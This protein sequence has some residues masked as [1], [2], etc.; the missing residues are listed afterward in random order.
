MLEEELH[1]ESK[2]PT[3]QKVLSKNK[4]KPSPVTSCKCFSQGMG[5]KNVYSKMYTKELPTLSCGKGF[6]REPRKSL[7]VG[8]EKSRC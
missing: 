7:S 3:N 8:G 6:N 5:G 4:N 2:E 1:L